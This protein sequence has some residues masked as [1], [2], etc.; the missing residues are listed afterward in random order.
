MSC[1]HSLPHHRKF[2]NKRQVRKSLLSLRMIAYP[3]WSSRIRDDPARKRNVPLVHGKWRRDLTLSAGIRFRSMMPTR[4]RL[5][6]AWTAPC[7]L[8]LTRLILP[9]KN[10]KKTLLPPLWL[11]MGAMRVHRHLFRTG[12]ALQRSI[13]I[14]K[15]HKSLRAEQP[16]KTMGKGSCINGKQPVRNRKELHSRKKQFH[17]HSVRLKRVARQSPL[18]PRLVLLLEKH[19]TLS[20]KKSRPVRISQ[21]VR[22]YLLTGAITLRPNWPMNCSDCVFSVFS[23]AI[24]PAMSIK[25]S[26]LL[27]RIS[28]R[29]PWRTGLHFKV[30]EEIMKSCLQEQKQFPFLLF[31]IPGIK[32]KVL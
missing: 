26:A 23:K 32:S 29:M 5:S 20:L 1:F 12:K 19:E 4:W 11:I 10:R 25:I 15:E 24:P 28:Q 16:I 13:L 22:R 9:G 6:K 8:G 17:N 30:A 31:L 27:P 7:N 18:P 14:R 3:G 21:G 2:R